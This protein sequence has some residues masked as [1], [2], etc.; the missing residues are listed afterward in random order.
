APPTPPLEEIRK[1]F[2]MIQGLPNIMSPTI[3][4]WPAPARSVTGGK[5]PGKV[6]KV[7]SALGVSSD[8]SSNSGSD[9]GD[10]SSD[11]DSENISMS[12][13]DA[14]TRSRKH[15]GPKVSSN[16]SSTVL[17]AKSKAAYGMDSSDDDRDMD[18]DRPSRV[19]K[20]GSVDA[21][22]YS[23]SDASRKDSRKQ[24]QYPS[25]PSTKNTTKRGRSYS[26]DE[27]DSEGNKKS[28]GISKD[29]KNK[30]SR[31]DI[32]SDSKKRPSEN[33]A[34]SGSAPGPDAKRTST[35]SSSS[36]KIKSEPVD[37]K[38]HRADEK[39]RSNNSDKPGRANESHSLSPVL[40]R[41]KDRRRRP[42]YSDDD[43]ND[44]EDSNKRR[45]SKDTKQRAQPE[46]TESRSRLESK[47]KVTRD[48]PIPNRKRSDSKDR[49]SEAANPRRKSKE[50]DNAR[51]TK[52]KTAYIE[53]PST[54]AS[55]KERRSKEEDA[56]ISNRTSGKNESSSKSDRTTSSAA[57]A[58]PSS[59]NRRSSR[60]GQKD[61]KSRSE[62]DSREDTKP[63]SE[64][65]SREDTTSSGQRNSAGNK[66]RPTKER[67]R[68]E[69]MTGTGVLLGT[70]LVIV[71]QIVTAEIMTTIVLR[72][73]ASKMADRG[74]AVVNATTDLEEDEVEIGLEET[75]VEIG[76]EIGAV[77]AVAIVVAIVVV[78]ETS[79]TLAN[80]NSGGR[81]DTRHDGKSQQPQQE[82]SK[83]SS[84]RRES[85]SK[86]SV[87]TT[88]SSSSSARR[89]SQAIKEE[90]SSPPAPTST[91]S[92]DA[93]GQQEIVVQKPS[94]SG[95]SNVA[96]V[97]R[98][99][100][101]DYQRKKG[102]TEKVDT[103]KATSDSP[104]LAPATALPG[105]QPLLS[106]DSSN[107][108]ASAD[109]KPSSNSTSAPKPPSET[110]KKAAEYYNIFRL[111][112]SEGITLKHNA[113]DT[114]KNQNN[115]RLG[116][117]QYF[118]SAI[119][120][121]AAF[122]AN[123]KYH[124]LTNP[125]RPDAAVKES[126]NSWET[127]RQFIYALTNQCHSNHLAGLDGVSVLMEALVYYKV[128]SF[129]STTLRKD[130]IKS[131]Q[132]KKSSAKG[133]DSA[134]TVTITQEMAS[135]MLQNVEDW[136]HI[137]KRMDDCRLW[138]TPD[139]ARKQFPET[140]RKWC[141][142]PD[143]I[144]QGQSFDRYVPGTTIQKIHWP[145]GLHLHLHELMGFVES[146]LEEF[147]KRND[148][149]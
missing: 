95:N 36:S 115:P 128:Y 117:I 134:P 137:Q 84:G 30:Q 8:E 129:Q 96:S 123:D 121:I 136:A 122:H 38:G 62:K 79:A 17:K 42:Y 60:E 85:E 57:A 112:R 47:D 82:S 81:G 114:L 120:F 65:D 100:F 68:E 83:A 143:Q 90:S 1:S 141:I 67:A 14:H 56:S 58:A 7:P 39:K 140:F 99:S 149:N 12:D 71:N 102:N 11:A 75:E 109:Q 103:P 138:L 22:R 105:K 145:L 52:E 116:A 70:M 49:N 2:E 6:P 135:R 44:L 16:S 119:E 125:G 35:T 124:I 89:P 26:S 10:S 31:D 66:E 92:S 72:R 131:G 59:P 48:D 113:D 148:L 43:D 127:M 28:K 106:K 118:L 130:M 126:I 9:S 69:G 146:A 4:S 97:K 64:K 142:H 20:E 33:G 86:S 139:I 13:A 87:P 46:T 41:N 45:S 88:V 80:P 91:S 93:R 21:G 53:K 34:G 55:N 107:K 74:T 51:E 5:Q 50:D 108:T 37:D 3:P 23:G 61:T 25:P 94:S 24:D 76:L 32:R 133:E 63:R 29:H 73:D 147:R 27:S 18:I 101:E 104:A 98:M 110:T 77:I 111:R 54:V 19:D 144:G 40:D 132:F 15:I 78:I